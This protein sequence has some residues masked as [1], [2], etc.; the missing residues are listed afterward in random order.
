MSR[1]GL[2]V[3]GTDTGVGKTWVGAQLAARLRALAVPL[4]PRKTVESGCIAHDGE[5]VPADGEA[6]FRAVGGTCP[7]QRITPYRLQHAISPQR[8][9]QLEG[10]DTTLANLFSATV[11]GVDAGDFLLVEGAG[12]FY[13]PLALDG[14][15]AD[16][17][18]RLQLP[19]LLVAPDRLGVIN[20][21]LLSVE[22]IAHRGLSLFAVVLN[23]LD[24]DD[25]LPPGMD[26][27][28][29]LQSL[30]CPVYRLARDEVLDAEH[31]LIQTLLALNT[32]TPGPS[33]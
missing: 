13:S 5:L 12:G 15:N 21:V 25:A 33:P 30:D 22:A 20:H 6:Y 26:N 7:L 24:K 32:L 11:E 4:V 23:R 8:A 18:A 14:L 17:A 10:A 28:T 2:F 16:F 19:V 3:T 31:P 1:R 27:V 9:A 29:D